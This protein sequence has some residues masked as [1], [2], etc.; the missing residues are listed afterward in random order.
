M[1]GL[2]GH[3]SVP[4]LA[5]SDL[6]QADF[7]YAAGAGS[8][9]LQGRRELTRPTPFDRRVAPSVSAARVADRA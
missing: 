2:D 3:R 8:A 1:R 7:S 9:S 6:A 5:P 4:A